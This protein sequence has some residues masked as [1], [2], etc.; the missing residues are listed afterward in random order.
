LRTAADHLADVASD[1]DDRIRRLVAV[2][3]GLDPAEGSALLADLGV[4]GILRV[5][6]CRGH[7]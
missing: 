4:R 1:P 2:A 5:L 3:R 6:P 7:A